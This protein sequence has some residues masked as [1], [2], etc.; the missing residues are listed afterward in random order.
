MRVLEATTSTSTHIR[1]GTAPTAPTRAEGGEQYSSSY[2]PTRP[3]FELRFEHGESGWI[4]EDDVSGVF[5]SGETPLDALHD[6]KR[7]VTEH[8]DVLSRQQHLSPGLAE[9]LEYLRQRI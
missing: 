8:I 3:G 6:F 7:A 1:S 4:W 9:Q 5:G 2:Q